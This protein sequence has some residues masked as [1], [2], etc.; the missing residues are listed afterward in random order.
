[1]RAT[2][3][4]PAIVPRIRAPRAGVEVRLPVERLR[5]HLLVARVSWSRASCANRRP[6]L[7]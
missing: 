7:D 6:E 1:M 4:V 3:D 2:P 5:G